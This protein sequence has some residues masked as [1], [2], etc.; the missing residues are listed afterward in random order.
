MRYYFASSKI[1]KIKKIA[2]VDEDVTKM[3]RNSSL[4]IAG[5]NTKWFSH[6]RK[7]FGRFLKKLHIELSYDLMILFL[8]IYPKKLKKGT[9]TSTCT[10]LTAPFTII[11]RRKQ[12]KCL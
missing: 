12:P 5:G 4:Y 9:Q 2:G 3:W 10:F 11:I 1:A 7:Q 8:G 6:C